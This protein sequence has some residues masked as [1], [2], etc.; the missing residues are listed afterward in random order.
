MLSLQ[1][2]EIILQCP[3]AIGRA[4]EPPLFKRKFSQVLNVSRNF[5]HHWQMIEG[6]KADLLSLP[7]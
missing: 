2:Q 6:I 3:V 4:L 1:L 5:F 7:V